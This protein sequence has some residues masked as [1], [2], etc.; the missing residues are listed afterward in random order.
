[1]KPFKKLQPGQWVS[2]AEYNRLIDVV[3]RQGMV[4]GNYGAGVDAINIGG[5]VSLSDPDKTITA[6]ITDGS[7]VPASGFPWVEAWTSGGNGVWDQASGGRIGT[8]SG[9]QAYELNGNVPA[10]GSVVKLWPGQ[11]G[12]YYFS[13]DGTHITGQS[14]IVVG[15]SGNHT[16]VVGINVVGQSGISVSEAAN[17]IT[18]G[19]N[20]GGASGGASPRYSYIDLSCASGLPP[21][22]CSG[23]PPA[24]GTA[25]LF[26]DSNCNLGFVARCCADPA[27]SYTNVVPSYPYNVHLKE[28]VRSWWHLDEVFPA[29]LGSG[30]TVPH[31]QWMSG[32][33]SGFFWED[34]CSGFQ[35]RP[36][37][38]LYAA[39]DG[40]PGIPFDAGN[41]YVQQGKV[42]SGVTFDATYTPSPPPADP[43]NPTTVATTN[44]G[45]PATFTDYATSFWYKIDGNVRAVGS[46]GINSLL[47]WA[48]L[49]LYVDVPG[50]STPFA[51]GTYDPNLLGTSGSQLYVNVGGTNRDTGFNLAMHQWH[52][53]GASYNSADSTVLVYVDG[54]S[55]VFSGALGTASEG[56]D[57][58]GVGA[59]TFSWTGNKVEFDEVAGYGSHLCTCD[60]DYLYDGGWDGS[61]GVW[62]FNNQIP[63]FVPASS[64]SIGPGTN[65]IASG[66]LTSGMMA[67]GFI[68]NLS[69]T[70]GSGSVQSGN[71]GVGAV[72]PGNIGAGAVLSGNIAAG[73]VQAGNLAG[74]SVLSGNLA[75]GSVNSGNITAG[76]IGMSQ[77]NTPLDFNNPHVLQLRH[78]TEASIPTLASGELWVAMDTGCLWAGTTAG[79]TKIGPT[80]GTATYAKNYLVNPQFRYNQAADLL[81]SGL[82]TSFISGSLFNQDRYVLDQWVSCATSGVLALFAPSPIYGAPTSGDL[83]GIE[84]PYYGRC[85]ATNRGKI[86]VYQPIE[87][88]NTQQFDGRTAYFS[89]KLKTYPGAS[90][91]TIKAGIVGHS[92]GGTIDSRPPSLVGSWDASTSG[93]DPVWLSGYTLLVSSDIAL[94]GDQWQTLSCNAAIRPIASGMYT[95]LYACFW[96]GNAYTGLDFQMAEAQLG[97]ASSPWQAPLPSEE[98]AACQRYFEKTYD[99]DTILGTSGNFTGEFFLQAPIGGSGYYTIGTP[100]KVSKRVAPTMYSYSRMGNSGRATYWNIS[101][102][103]HSGSWTWQGA[104]F[105]GVNETNGF[106]DNTSYKDGVSL[107]WAADSRM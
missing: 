47:T 1:M 70:L 80:S 16:T 36:G 63:S 83:I 49:N 40:S 46:V 3:E 69:P 22:S 38:A 13:L 73:A 27:C 28:K 52:F 29:I 86:L 79:N 26:V 21:V 31:I 14:G 76:S 10:S 37:N 18:I 56:M 17:T 6:I 96:M 15:Q 64:G 62:P 82:P 71:L 34:A 88:L 90:G 89:V 106:T 75:A 11:Q 2:A 102:Q 39:G 60:F 57:F 9:G 55:V 51:S 85:E 107:Q 105:R 104:S 77:L 91:T 54:S 93:S 97:L 103:N 84:S 87:Y 66:T 74:G 4:Q 99:P 101:T 41:C 65:L 95:N 61:P 81:V 43:H 8:L 33:I 12:E 44:I 30:V 98:L 100:F 50:D 7:G 42:I 59:N 35:G 20:P 68:A 32:G 58:G 92:S 23:S 72:Q 5:T 53:I 78:G 94:K 25:Q 24:S 45:A 67:S 48:G 19:Y